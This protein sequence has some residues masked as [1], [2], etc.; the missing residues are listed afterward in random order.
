MTKHK[1]VS[2]NLND[3]TIHETYS[4][5]TYDRSVIDSILYRKAY[6]RVSDAEWQEVLMSLNKY[7]IEEMISH[8][9]SLHNLRLY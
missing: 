5:D 6:N 3:N 2:F 1:V 4:S 7:K 9:D 8:K